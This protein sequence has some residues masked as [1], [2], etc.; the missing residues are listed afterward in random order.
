M[1]VAHETF[2]VAGTI[3]GGRRKWRAAAA[4]GCRRPV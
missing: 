3:F 2:S 4:T 1:P